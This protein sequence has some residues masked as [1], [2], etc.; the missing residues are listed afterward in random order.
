MTQYYKSDAYII[1][2]ISLTISGFLLVL[3]FCAWNS[4]YSQ[5]CVVGVSIPDEKLLVWWDGLRE[6]QRV[7]NVC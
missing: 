3:F 6:Q 4:R 5:E 2:Y 7:E 1:Y